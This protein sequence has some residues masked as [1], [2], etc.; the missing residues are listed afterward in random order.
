MD[1]RARLIFPPCAH[2]TPEGSEIDIA[3]PNFVLQGFML[4][5]RIIYHL[6]VAM[7]SRLNLPASRSSFLIASSPLQV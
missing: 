7:A 5:G 4:R 2:H 3:C 1:A 6:A